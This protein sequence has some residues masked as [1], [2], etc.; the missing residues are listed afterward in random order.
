MPAPYPEYEAARIAALRR[1][2]ILDTPAEEAFDDITRLASMVCGAPIS[3]ISLID[4]AR[5]WFKS[6][7]GLDVTQT[8]RDLA[9][10]AH[11]ILQPDTLIVP[12]A[13]E[14]ARFAANPLVVDDP[15]I[16]FYAGAPLITQDGHALGTLCV[17][18]RL[19]R[20]LTPDQQEALQVLARQVVAQLELRQK[21][22]EQEEAFALQRQMAQ[23]L[24][25]SHAR[26]EAFM[27]T[28]PFVAFMKDARGR[29]LYIN[30][31]FERFFNVSLE[32]IWGTGDEDLFSPEVAAQ[33]RAS[34]EAVFA[35]GK[36]VEIIDV[37]PAPNGQT[38]TW[39]AYKFPFVD[40]AGQ[41]CVGGVAVDVTERQRASIALRHSEARLA[42]AQRVAH[43]GSWE[44][45]IAAGEIVWS[46]ETFRLL[47]FDPNE[48]APS[49]EEL[50]RRY[51]PDDRPMHRDMVQKCIEDGVPYEF[52]VRAVLQD[53][54]IRW[55]HAL[56]QAERDEQGRVA[57]LFG[58]V[59][60]KTESKR[61][62]QELEAANV[63]LEAL[64]T[65]DGLTGLK[66]HRSFQEKL[67]Q[68]FERS[69][70]YQ[71]PLSVIL[72]DVDHFK[73]FNDAF[74]HPA[75][76]EVLKRVA[77]T[78]QQAAR[79]TDFV[80]RYGGEEFVIVL[81]ETGAQGA[82]KVAERIR[83][84]IAGQAWERRAIT[85]SIGVTSL[86]ITAPSPAALVEEADRALYMSKQN[87]RN[88]VT[89]QPFAGK[90]ATA[91]LETV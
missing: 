38:H 60:D 72:L 50:L 17:I 10:C 56:G 77:A 57:R 85:V 75:G 32:D 3:L 14:D 46:A 90:P 91:A 4:E 22:R 5:Q 18:D 35:S 19:P 66:N 28:S 45:D 69:S 30:K 27:N 25:D 65:M 39:R 40:P 53:G 15:N 83:E 7:V 49:Y 44:F 41:P 70:R 31:P 61:Q 20:D 21:I 63:R 76:D 47:E 24:H 1:Y 51:H 67:A 74:G 6:R 42:Q 59:R 79:T 71:T 52:D 43:I 2:H 12:N 26:F 36:P 68:E 73:Q 64:A 78:L 89:L 62:Q 87:G 8:P 29:Y 55:I 86:Q 33:N 80:A 88:R 13:L 34:D 82:V 58:T 37:V 11:A 9:F 84:A 23:A 48:G 54:S 16:R 81:P